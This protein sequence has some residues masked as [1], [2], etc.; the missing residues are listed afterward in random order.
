M[1]GQLA[2]VQS[3]LTL[4]QL[5]T[6]TVKDESGDSAAAAN[7]S[8]DLSDIPLT[9]YTG[10]NFPTD[11]AA[12]NYMV[13]NSITIDK[14]DEFLTYSAT[15]SDPSLVTASV[16]NEWLTLNY[17]A[18]ETGTAA[19]TVTATDRYGA[20]VKD[21]FNVTVAV[22]IRGQFG[23]DRGRQCD[24]ADDVDGHA[25]G[26]RSAELADHVRVPVVPKRHGYFRRDFSVAQFE[27]VDHCYRRQIHRRRHAQRLGIT[28]TAVTSS[29]ITVASG[30]P[31]SF[32]PPA[33][34]A[35]TI[36]PDNA[37]DATTLTANVIQFGPG[38]LYLSVAA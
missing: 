18:G 22:G 34:T 8:V 1:F 11:A 36:A 3:D 30:S 29:P 17:A 21:T 25:G 35:V 4:S 5:A 12:G 14:Q 9:N 27:P 24:N 28:G 16:N 2:D 15:S 23:L 38:D 32:Q 6:T 26:Q 7:P 33:V 10:T 31:L 13:I 37:S 20:T 19:I